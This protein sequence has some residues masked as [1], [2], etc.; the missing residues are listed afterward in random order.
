M[1][2]AC[3]LA[4]RCHA[5][6]RQRAACH[7]YS[8]EQCYQC[9]RLSHFHSLSHWH[10]CFIQILNP[11]ATVTFA[12]VSVIVPWTFPNGKPFM[13][14]TSRIHTRSQ[15]KRQSHSCCRNNYTML[16]MHSSCVIPAIVPIINAVTLFQSLHSLEAI[17]IVSCVNNNK[18]VRIRPRNN[19]TITSIHFLQRTQTAP[20]W[21]MPSL[22]VIGNSSPPN[23]RR[24]HGNGNLLDC[25]APCHFSCKRSD[26]PRMRFAPTQR[27]REPHAPA[28]G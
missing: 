1:L 18:R 15:M 21:S 3:G 7:S 22:N 10:D 19:T 14:T 28:R 20:R 17:G 6:E 25:N 27:R 5:Q 23:S 13:A 9:K 8:N 2:A 11:Q 26:G 4:S 24:W 12:V 16:K